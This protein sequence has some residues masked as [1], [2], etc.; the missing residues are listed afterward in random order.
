MTDLAQ[1]ALEFCKECLGWEDARLDPRPD[2]FAVYDFTRGEWNG[3]RFN[4]LDPVLEAVRYWVRGK[5]ER[6][7]LNISLET[8]SDWQRWQVEFYAVKVAHDD[9]CYAL[10]AAC[11]ETNRKLSGAG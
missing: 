4:S 8:G 3:L 2:V 6:A 11:V 9:L 7:W 1:I 10:L 5:N